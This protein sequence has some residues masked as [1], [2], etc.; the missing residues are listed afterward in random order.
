MRFSRWMPLLLVALMAVCSVGVSADEPIRALYITGGG[1]H[2]YQ[3]QESIIT[4][5]IKRRVFVEWTIEHE[6]GTASNQIPTRW[7]DD[8]WMDGFD[9]IVYNMCYSEVSDTELIESI[10]AMHVEKGIPAMVLHCAM[11]S[12]RNSTTAWFDFIGVRTRVHEAERPF[13]VENL[14]PQH[15]IMREFPERWQTPNGELYII[16]AVGPNTQVLARAYGVD[17]QKYHPVIWTNEY[18]GV[19]V[20]GTTI[21]HHN[22]TMQHPVYLDLISRGMLWATNRWDAIDQIVV[23]AIYTGEDGPM[24][25]PAVLDFAFDGTIFFAERR[26][27]VNQLDPVTGERIELFRTP[28]DVYLGNEHGLM[29]MALEPGFDFYEKNHIYIFYSPADKW[30]TNYLSRFEYRFDE[31]GRPYLDRDSEEIIREIPTW[32][33]S[34]HPGGDIRFGPDGKLYIALGDNINP[35]ESSGYAPI[36][37]RPGREYFNALGTSSNP[38]D[39]RGKIL[40]INPDGTVPEDNPFYGNPDYLDE[41]WALGFRNP[42]RIHIDPITGWVLVGDNGPDAGNLNP[43]R[44]PAGIASWKLVHSPGLHFGWPMCHG[45]NIPYFDWDFATNSSTGVLFDCSEM[46]PSLVW[47]TYAQTTQFPQLRSGG[48]SPIS[49]VI[50]RQP[51]PDAPYQW[52]EHHLNHWYAADFS[53]G[54]IARFSL[55][56][57]GTKVP[58]HS[59]W[60]DHDFVPGPD[61]NRVPAPD[62]DV[63]IFL[64]QFIQPIDLRQSPDGALY[65]IDYGTAWNQ[66]NK[67]AAIYRIYNKTQPDPPSVEVTAEPWSGQAPLTVTFTALQTDTGTDE[68]TAYE[69]DFGDGGTASG[70]NVTHTYTE[71]GVYYAT[72]QVTGLYNNVG[73]SE[74]V[75]IVVGNTAP[76]PEIE[77]PLP[78]AI[79]ESGQS[80]VLQGSAWDAEDGEVSADAL[81]WEVVAVYTVNGRQERE[82]VLEASGAEARFTTHRDGALNWNTDLSYIIRLTATDSEG[83]SNSVER[84]VRYARL[85]AQLADDVQGFTFEPTDDVDGVLHAVTDEAGS[86]LAFHEVNVTGR[87]A[88]FVQAKAEGG[89]L[90]A[91]ILDDPANEPVVVRPVEARSAWS[92]VLMP[93]PNDLEGV[94]DLYLVVQMIGSGKAAINWVQLVGAGLGR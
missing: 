53:R 52:R 6:V 87:N 21:G 90:I 8:N 63:S 30:D 93:L 24:R 32:H 13:V 73:R 18:E 3:T 5:G 70:P 77:N 65:L 39:L 56:E 94:H 41:I 46:T 28:L 92:P 69:W 57:G 17:T 7:L 88:M 89:A 12:L 35:F 58:D 62:L 78:G 82:V 20:F 75:V 79:Y 44:G 59:N 16:E 84:I 85:Q 48:M 15:P 29:G 47:M 4:Q 51:S 64:D 49:G 50:L 83:L 1:W 68:I 72:V 66:P 22:V 25:E 10:V 67:D 91:L 26:G 40:R 55:E 76:E 45:P 61:Y 23:E 71:E 33:G 42:Y 43:N 11:H 81:R 38:L 86:Y 14:A 34:Y 37:R 60:Y 31:N 36:D 80:F 2:D 74:P 54:F 9:I 19:R 27:Q